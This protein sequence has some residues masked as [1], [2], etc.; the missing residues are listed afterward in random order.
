MLA[1]GG[2]FIVFVFGAGLVY[3]INVV[4]S[5]GPTS[6]ARSAKRGRTTEKASSSISNTFRTDAP[7]MGT[8]PILV[9]STPASVRQ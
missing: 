2:V 6:L 7:E 5:G 9:A 1:I 4:K 8:T 3:A